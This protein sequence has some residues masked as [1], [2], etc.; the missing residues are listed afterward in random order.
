[1]FMKRRNG[2]LKRCVAMCLLGAIAVTPVLASVVN[3]TWTGNGAN[4]HWKITTT[5]NN[6]GTTGQPWYP[7]NT[8]DYPNVHNVTID[9]PAN[10]NGEVRVNVEYLVIGHLFL[11]DEHTLELDENG[12][13]VKDGG[14]LDGGFELEGQVKITGVGDSQLLDCKYISVNSTLRTDI[15][16]VDDGHAGYVFTNDN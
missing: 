14:G 16:F 11:G 4:D 12:L 15:E 8:D 1:M 2:C 13:V 3:F 7:N 10:H 5:P 6:W 9:N